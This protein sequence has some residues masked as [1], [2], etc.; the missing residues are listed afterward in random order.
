M[1]I[2]S[3]WILGI[4]L[5]IVLSGCNGLAPTTLPPTDTPTP[6]QPPT[7][8]PVPTPTF[9]PTPEP[10][11]TTIVVV[12]S[13]GEEICFLYISPTTDSFWG[14]DWLSA[15]DTI[16]I[17]ET[18]EFS[19]EPDVYDML[20]E[21]CDE[22]EI[23]SQWAISV[24]TGSRWVWEVPPRP[25][26]AGDATLTLVNNLDEPI[27]NVY[28]SLVTSDYWGVDW[29]GPSEVIR[30]GTVRPFQVESGEY[31]MLIEDCDDN[32][33]DTAWNVSITGEQVWSVGGE[34]AAPP[35]EDQPPVPASGNGTVYLES[36]LT[37]S[38][39]CRISVWG[40]GM[41]FVL[42]AQV[43]APASREVPPGD[44]GWQA[45]LGSGESGAD[46]I[47]ISPGGSCYFTCYQEGAS[48]YI[49][50]GCSP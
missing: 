42:D 12:N 3:A 39:T 2:R 27:C 31:D 35:P 5:M 19:V 16:S 17:G 50:W 30:P 37:D 20:V 10:P 36:E 22:T 15:T 14:D 18:R 1:R 28:I 33:L 4:V 8:T 26:Q 29:L 48:Q 34:S 45:F 24:G 32:E 23:D 41:E 43:G 44:Y 49:G 21:N 11:E 38:P 25:G 7:D 13:S 47:H 46:S 9:T 40:N 6:T